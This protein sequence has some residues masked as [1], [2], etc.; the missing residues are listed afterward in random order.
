MDQPHN[1]NRVTCPDDDYSELMSLALD[2]LLA[3]EESLRLDRHLLDCPRCQAEWGKWQRIAH[4]LEVEPFAGPPQGFA[5]NVDRVLQRA[6]QRRERILGGLV[7][8]G[9]TLSL[10]ALILLTAGLT[11]TLWL[12]ISPAARLAAVEYF[13]F[14]RQFAVLVFQNVTA[15]RDA[16]LALLPDPTALLL[17]VLALLTAS[18]LWIRLVFFGRGVSGAARR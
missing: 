8:A 13:A 16:S 10:S 6:E 3:P 18:V 14:A 15:L 4:V 2:G 11:M 17:I 1:H 7:L 12:A 5:M 9:G